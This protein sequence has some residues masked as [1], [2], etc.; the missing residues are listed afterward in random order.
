[1]TDIYPHLDDPQFQKKITLKKEFRY[2]YDGAISSVKEKSKTM[3]KKTSSFELS[4]HQEFVRKFISYQNPYNSLLLYHGLGSG[5]TCSAISITESL[6]MYSKY[7]P[8][9]KKILM[10]ASPNVQENFKLQLFDP[11]K[12]TRVNGLWNLHGCVGNTLLKELNIDNT[13]EMKRE[14]LIYRIRKI[15]KDNY[16]FIGYGSFAN[17]I[18]KQLSN[19]NIKKLQNMFRSR[20]IVIDEIHNIRITEKSSDSIGKKIASM[21]NKLVQYVK[22]IKFIFLT[23]TPMYNDPKEIIYLLNLMNLNDNRTTLQIKDVFTESGELKEGGTEKL[24][25]KANGY[26]SYVRGE[27]PYVFPYMITPSMFKDPHSSL[28]STPP[29]I[30]FNDKKITPIEHLDLYE[31]SL[32]DHQENAYLKTIELIEEKKTEDFE[33]I[34]SLGYN[35]LMKPIQHLLITYPHEEGYYTGDEGLQYVMQYRESLYPPSRNEFVYNDTPL[36]GMFEYDQIGKYSSKIKS[37]LDNILD[38][39]GIVLV[40]SQYINGGLVPI[41]LALEELG[42]K[43]FGEKSKTLFRDKKEDLN[44]YN[45]KRESY[46]GKFKQAKYAIISGEKML[47]PDNNEEIY[48]LTHDNDEGQQIKVVLISQA[49]TEGIDLKNVRQVHV[50]EP[51][52]NLNRIEQIIGRA[53]RNCSHSELPLSERNFTLFLYTSVL[54]EKKRESLDNLL[55][56]MAEKKSIKIGKVSRILKSVSVDCLLNQEQQQFAKMTERISLVLSNGQKIIYD[57]KDKP[58]SSLCDYSDQC[59][60]QCINSVSPFEKEDILTYSYKDTQNNKLEDKI[61]TL[62]SKKHV[63]TKEEILTLIRSPLEELLRTLTDMIEQKIPISDKYSKPGYLVQVADLYLFQPMELT[64]PRTLLYDRTRPIP[65]HPKSYVLDT[66]RVDTEKVEERVETK[67]DKPKN[68]LDELEELYKRATIPSEDPDEDWYTLFPKASDYMKKHT[69]ITDDQLEEFLIHHLCEQLNSEKEWNVLQALE[70]SELNE[71]Q[72]KIKEYYENKYVIKEEITAIGLLTK[73]GN[74]SSIVPYI[75]TDYSWRKATP[76]EKNLFEGMYTFEKTPM[77]STIGFMGY[78]TDH[79]YQFKIKEKKN[80]DTRGSYLL[81]KKKSDIIDFLNEVILKKTV[82]TKENTKT[83]K[84]TRTE[85]S[86]LS[87]LYMRYL[88][89]TKKERYFLSKVEYYLYIEKN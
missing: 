35:D 23:G 57:V 27:N 5:K 59:E 71:F 14:D 8:H 21:L 20:I 62:F 18:E 52:Y 16:S 77:H 68:V 37:L 73:E 50:M 75:K 51:W 19:R 6:R 9:F 65:F 58:F 74:K 24:Q 67:K 48:A 70:S 41:A 54:K 2:R 3:C 28:L 53:R 86:I 33:N 30:Q 43:R 69:S 66:Q 79:T 1:M 36:K 49:G 89:R 83:N 84:I 34:D 64:D 87:E 39:K 76:T 15:I 17:F 42:M 61:K 32:S 88:D 12:L 47:S 25:E 22:G 31:I 82:F 55:Y 13:Q 56:R 38:S 63:Y 81:I 26:I 11:S 60:Y 44:V 72:E 46:Q 29:T 7:V 78:Y 80:P 4:P 45:L 40:Y 10:V 85:L